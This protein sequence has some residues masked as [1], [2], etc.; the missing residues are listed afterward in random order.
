MFKEYKG[1]LDFKREVF[2]LF[3]DILGGVQESWLPKDHLL[4]TQNS[5]FQEVGNKAK[6]AGDQHGQE[7]LTELRH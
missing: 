6:A 3:R 2:R 5:P 7:V 4:E 1:L